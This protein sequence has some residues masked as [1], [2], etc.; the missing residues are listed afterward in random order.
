MASAGNV[1]LQ[2]YYNWLYSLFLTIAPVIML[3]VNDF[4]IPKPQAAITP[5]LYTHG[6]KRS[7]FNLPGF[8][9]WCAEGLWAAA[10]SVYLPLWAQQN[11]MGGGAD[12]E[13]F[14]VRCSCTQ[15]PQLHLAHAHSTCTRTRRAPAR[16]HPRVHPHAHLLPPFL[17]VDRCSHG[18]P[19]PS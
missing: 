12:E 10:V 18:C 4:D 6:I 3:G 9:H 11:H 5:Q 14:W 17:G 15:D 13:S 1:Y 16:G 2:F 19:C 7:Y 8:A